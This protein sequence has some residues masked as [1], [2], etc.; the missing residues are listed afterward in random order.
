MYFCCR[1]PSGHPGI[2]LRMR[3][4]WPPFGRHHTLE[5]R[6]TLQNTTHTSKIQHPSG[7][8]ASH[9]WVLPLKG[10]CRYTT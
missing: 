7:K 2:S 6:C 5:Q 3:W 9:S 1:E 8:G 10:Y 4:W